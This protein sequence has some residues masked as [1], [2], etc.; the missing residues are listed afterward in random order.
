MN[1][2]RERILQTLE[3][4]PQALG[5]ISIDI[6]TYPVDQIQD[7]LRRMLAEGVIAKSTSKYAL[8]HADST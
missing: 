2:L 5:E 8:R 4:G 3:G 7:E 1:N 6:L